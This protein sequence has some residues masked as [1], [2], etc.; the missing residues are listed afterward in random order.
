TELT[1]HCGMLNLIGE[2]PD[3]DAVL[4]IPGAHLHLYGKAPQPGR[5]LGHITLCAKT[6]QQLK[7]LLTRVPGI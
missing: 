2:I 3:I 6:E 7:Q 5:K 1:G 4:A